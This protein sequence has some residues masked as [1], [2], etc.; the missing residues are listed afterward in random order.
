MVLLRRTDRAARMQLIAGRTAALETL[1]FHE[2]R[3]HNLVA[4]KH[5]PIAYYR[6]SAGAEIDFVIESRKRQGDNPPRLVC[7]EVKLAPRWQRKWERSI[8]ALGALESVEIARMVGVYTGEREYHFD[9]LDVMPVGRFLQRLH[10][11][12][13]F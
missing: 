2:I 4:A 5:R 1:V 8:R 3:V 9:G 10:A 7:V 11:G 13:V 12:E 6:T